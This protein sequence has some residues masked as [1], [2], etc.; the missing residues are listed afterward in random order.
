[1]QTVVIG[2]FSFQC[3][4]DAIKI[5]LHKYGS[6]NVQLFPHYC[7]KLAGSK[8]EGTPLVLYI[9]QFCHAVFQLSIGRP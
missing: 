4:M 9:S 1:M 7:N 3:E 5:L 2:I 8:L 6:C